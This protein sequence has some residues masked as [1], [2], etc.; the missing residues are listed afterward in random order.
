[1]A[2]E[3]VGRLSAIVSPF[4]PLGLHATCR[5]CDEPLPA[6]ASRASSATSAALRHGDD[7][8]AAALS[9]ARATTRRQ[10][11]RRARD[12]ACC[13]S[14]RSP[15][16]TCRSS[17]AASS[18][19]WRRRTT[20]RCW[21]SR[22]RWSSAMACCAS[23][24]PAFGELRDAL[25][26]TVQQRA[27]RDAG[28]A[29]LPASARAQPALP[30]RPPDRR[31]VARD[32]A[33]H[34]RHPVGAAAR[35]VQRRADAARDAAGHRASSGTCSTGA[36]PR[37][38]SSPSVSYV[39]FTLRFAGWRVRIRRTMNETDND[40]RTKAL[41]SL[42]NYETVK[43]FGNEAHEAR[44]LRRGAGALRARRGARAGVAEHAEP[45]PGARSSRSG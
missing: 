29:D 5:P 3:A 12:G 19:R 16:S 11:P 25:F 30:P 33:R 41:D 27:V 42:L 43:Y 39:G 24:P 36:S 38:P 9:L 20:R 44:A 13:C 31:P 34:R 14:P 4:K 6:E 8:L 32:R 23:A 37:S 35:G 2:Q 40:A 15:P 1:M 22:W 7:P 18:M 26:A 28:A 17:M 45:R 21:R 10:G